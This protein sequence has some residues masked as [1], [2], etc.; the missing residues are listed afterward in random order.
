MNE[1][2]RAFLTSELSDLPGLFLTRGGRCQIFFL[3]HLCRNLLLTVNKSS[4]APA[5]LSWSFLLSSLVYFQ[6]LTCPSAQHSE[7]PYVTLGKGVSKHSRY[8]GWPQC[9]RIPLTP[10]TTWQIAGMKLEVF[11]LSGTAGLSSCSST[12]CEVWQGEPK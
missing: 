10:L 1:C 5:C 3:A 9:S 11:F 7:E 4:S 8:P 6:R 12:C 2:P